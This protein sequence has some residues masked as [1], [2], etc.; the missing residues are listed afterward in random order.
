VVRVLGTLDP[1]NLVFEAVEKSFLRRRLGRIGK[2]FRVDLS[3]D[4]V[5]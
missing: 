3:L 1:A 4:G 2:F 5:Y